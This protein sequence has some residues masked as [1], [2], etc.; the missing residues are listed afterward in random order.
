VKAGSRPIDTLVSA[1]L[2]LAGSMARLAPDLMTAKSQIIEINLRE[3]RRAQHNTDSHRL[4]S[5][6][7]KAIDD[8]RNRP[9]AGQQFQFL[10]SQHCFGFP[11][12]VLA[13]RNAVL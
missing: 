4:L 12:A 7:K 10:E 8:F 2:W 9:L 13:P 5:F 3:R 11:S 6:R 1:A